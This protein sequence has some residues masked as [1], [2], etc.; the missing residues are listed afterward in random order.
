MKV[1]TAGARRRVS[2]AL[3]I[4]GGALRGSAGSGQAKQ[5]AFKVAIVTDIGALNDKGVQPASRSRVSTRPSKD[6][7][8]RRA[9]IQTQLRGGPHPEP[10]GRGQAGLRPRHRE[11]V[12]V[13]LRPLNTVARRSR[14]RSSLGI[15]VNIPAVRKKPKN[16]R[17]VQFREQ[18]AGCLVGNI[19]GAGGQEAGRP[20]IISAVGANKVP[21]IV[22]L[23]RRLQLVREEGE[24]EDQGP[25]Q[26]RERPDLQRPGEVQGRP[27]SARSRAARRSS[28]RSPA[29]AASVRSMPPTRQKSSGASASTP[30]STTSAST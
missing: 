20:Q 23:H 13:R 8:S 24:P 19:A 9:S 18:E 4:A 28:S 2:D 12:P 27:R 14:T 29:A 21:A 5:A 17:G 15:D 1:R 30:T 26:L 22:T 6:S 7:A 3:V 11:R 10:A 25:G 16:V